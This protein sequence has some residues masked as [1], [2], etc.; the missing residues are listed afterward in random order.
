[1][2]RV[3]K[4]NAPSVLITSAAAEV[5]AMCE[6][7]D[8]A[9]GAYQRGEK[10][11]EFKRSIYASQQVKNALEA[12]HYG[13][14]C[15]CET[16]VPKPYAHTHVEHYR[17]K[18]FSQQA[19]GDT[20]IFPGYYWLAY[21]WD[22]L[23]LSC[24]FCNSSNKGNLFP[25]SDPAW[26]ARHHNMSIADEDPEIL[27]PDGAENPRADIG[28]H[29]DVPIDLSGKGRRTIDI[30]GLD[31][32]KHEMRREHFERIRIARSMAVDLTHS[33]D[34]LARGYAGAAKAL[35]QKAVQI[36]EPYSAMVL[37]YLAANPIP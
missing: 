37:D 36:D 9:P 11:F 34:P 32:P 29:E 6:A 4:G 33:N 10:A 30:L 7:Y 16:R 2:I 24:H 8:G 15:Y 35:L 23:L 22:N 31:S 17:P 19:P 21:D 1:V 27:K 20:Q 28:F 12:S 25:L 3:E 5:Q 13:K 18:A 26:R 14:C